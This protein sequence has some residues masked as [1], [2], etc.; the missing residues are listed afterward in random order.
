MA[1]IIAVTL[2]R[3]AASTAGAQ[4]DHR[5]ARKARPFHRRRRGS[6]GSQHTRHG[7]KAPGCAPPVGGRRGP[8]RARGRRAQHARASETGAPGRGR[9]ST[10]GSTT[11]RGSSHGRHG[12]RE[13][14]SHRHT[15]TT[16]GAARGKPGSESQ[17]AATTDNRTKRATM[18]TASSKSAEKQ[19]K[20]ESSKS[21]RAAPTQKQRIY[22]L[23]Y[24]R[25]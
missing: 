12:R 23:V 14:S 21:S 2:P 7:Q 17:I 11:R 19:T 24:T 25:T 18:F 9:T 6:I 1:A 13:S 5:R 15:H 10:K 22:V 4:N 8:P 3:E 16:P 20:A